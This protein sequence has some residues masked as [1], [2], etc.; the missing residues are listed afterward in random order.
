VTANSSWDRPGPDLALSV[1]VPTRGG[2][3]RLPVLLDALAAQDLEE[4]WEVVLVLDGD[5]DGSREVVEAYTDR[6]PLSIV[7]FGD[8]QGRSAALNAGFARARGEVLVRCDDDL[9]P[10]VDYLARHA[11]RHA[12]D[13]VGVVGLYRNVFPETTYARVYGREWD[14][15][16][17]REA[18]AAAADQAWRY[19]AGN[20][21][22]TRET[23]ERVGPYDTDF[24][25]YGY[26]DVDWGYRLAALGVPIVLDPRLETEHRIASTTSA[27]RAQ[28]AFYS[29]AARTRFELKHSIRTPP[30]PPATT[31]DRL[32]SLVARRLDEHRIPRLGRAVDA[33]ARPLPDPLARKAVAML[34]EAAALAGHARGQTTG[35]I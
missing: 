24:R 18:Y 35:A 16:F 20:C 32:V 12:G 13:V 4:P 21:S 14:A 22:V 26:E 29:G 15:R 1:V 27:V 31:W 6:V 2:A 33:C 34:V 17:R 11:A 30:R 28:R 25:A 5:I 10:S 9:V 19:W 23:W 8:N 7:E 3:R